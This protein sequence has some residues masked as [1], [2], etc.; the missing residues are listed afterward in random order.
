ML[1]FRLFLRAFPFISI[2]T[3]A[4]LATGETQSLFMHKFISEKLTENIESLSIKTFSVTKLTA[5][6]ATVTVFTDQGTTI[7]FF[8]DFLS[9]C[10]TCGD[11]QTYE[12]PC[13]HACAAA[14]VLDISQRD[15]KTIYSSR[16]C[17]QQ[18]EQDT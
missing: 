16:F 9:R 11:F 8:V 12:S 5:Y 18:E 13:W 6:T 3:K 15:L 2:R 1:T 4:E 14:K 10:C 17:V 7:D